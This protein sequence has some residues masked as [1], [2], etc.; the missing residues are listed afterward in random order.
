MKA[1]HPQYH[2]THDVFHPYRLVKLTM[3]HSSAQ[4]MHTHNAY[5]MKNLSLSSFCNSVLLNSKYRKELTS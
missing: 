5:P 1:K 4:I 2:Q 3:Y